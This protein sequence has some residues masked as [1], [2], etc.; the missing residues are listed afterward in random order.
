MRI[1]TDDIRQDFTFHVFIDGTEVFDCVMADDEKG[2]IEAYK[3]RNGKLIPDGDKF[4]MIKQSGKVV[5][6]KRPR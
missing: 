2:E 6:E 3:M 1:T 5:I 4:K